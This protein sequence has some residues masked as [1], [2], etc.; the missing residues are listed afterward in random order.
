M[1]I[2]EIKALLKSRGW[3]REQ[4]GNRV[5]VS[6]RTVDNWLCGSYTIPL[7]KMKLIEELMQ[8]S[9]A[10]AAKKPVSVDIGSIEII[11]VILTREEME[12]VARAAAALGL[13]IDE[14]ARDA[15]LT[16]TATTLKE[17]APAPATAT[18]PAYDA[19][20]QSPYA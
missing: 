12:E 18:A 7:P 3:N 2:E 10:P 6:K 13:S 20:A 16:A 4:F 19:E 1:E 8:E 17:N 11:N 15:V 14:F 9:A 5:G